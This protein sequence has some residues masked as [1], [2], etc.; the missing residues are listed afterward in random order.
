MFTANDVLRL[1]DWKDP[2]DILD[3]V[4]CINECYYAKI[5]ENLVYIEKHDKE[6][7]TTYSIELRDAYSHL[8]RIFAYNDFSSEENKIKI[9]RQLE[10]YLGHLEELLYDTYLRKIMIMANSFYKKIERKRELPGKKMEYAK[11]ISQ[12][13]TLNDDI[14]V[15]QKIEKYDNLIKSIERD[16]YQVP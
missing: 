4:R 12:L 7:Y 2:G 15:K 13:R 5:F 3:N 11:Q 14:T 10:R 1:D 16:D 6:I 9:N 8:V